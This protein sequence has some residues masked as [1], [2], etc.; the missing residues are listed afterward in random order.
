MEK[1]NVLHTEKIISG[2]RTYYFDLKRSENGRDYLL[3]S[4]RRQVEEDKYERQQ[5]ILFEEGLR[6]FGGMLMEMM[7]QFEGKNKKK[8]LTEE[9][10]AAVRKEYPN[11]FIPW[12]AEEDQ[13]LLDMYKQGESVDVIAQHF[14]R[15][16]SAISYRIKKLDVQ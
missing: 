3:I 16:P 1:Q 7:L 5:I 12:T 2:K 11:A 4:E 8:R 6:K 14:L 9:E 13:T 15:K 10:I